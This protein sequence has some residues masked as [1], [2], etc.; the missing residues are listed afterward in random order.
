MSAS[1]RSVGSAKSVARIACPR[2]TFVH[3]TWGTTRTFRLDLPNLF[4]AVSDTLRRWETAFPTEMPAGLT[5][6]LVVIA[7]SRGL[8][9][10]FLRRRH[11][12]HHH[13]QTCKRNCNVSWPHYC[14]PRD[15][16]SA[17]G[18][19]DPDTG[20]WQQDQ[21]L[22]NQERRALGSFNR[23]AYT[24]IS[25]VGVALTRMPYGTAFPTPTTL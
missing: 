12:N 24:H 2:A 11:V 20:T 7:E 1:G 18:H 4:E 17:N 8:C 6:V 3:D 22:G 15:T 16:K 21:T 13:S 19:W 9:N 23:L 25:L 10:G 5:E 14:L